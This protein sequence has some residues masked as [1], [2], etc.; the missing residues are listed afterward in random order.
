V[1][2]VEHSRVGKT[3]AVGLPIKF[4]ETPGGVRRGAPVLGEHTDEVLASLGYSAE[5]IAALRAE[6]A[7]A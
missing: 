7:V 5:R 1:V 2:E 4:S 6:G 3:K